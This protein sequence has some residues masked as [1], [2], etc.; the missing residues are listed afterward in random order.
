VVLDMEL[1]FTLAQDA[2]TSTPFQVWVP[3]PV[4]PLCDALEP[5]EPLWAMSARPPTRGAIARNLDS[6]LIQVPPEK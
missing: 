2:S 6:L 5:V 1:A 3:A 4:T